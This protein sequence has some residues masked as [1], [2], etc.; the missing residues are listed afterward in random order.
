MIYKICNIYIFF[1][2]SILLAACQQDAE[3]VIPEVAD[4]DNLV[5][6][7]YLAETGTALV[8]GTLSAEV[9]KLNNRELRR[10]ENS[11]DKPHY[12]G[13]FF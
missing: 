5:T 13:Y 6:S 10:T 2:I 4:N 1:A 12:L 7:S 11:S 3:I 8:N 9:D